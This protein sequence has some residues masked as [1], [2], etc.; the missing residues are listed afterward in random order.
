[1]HGVS[2]SASLPPDS[3]KE[4]KIPPVPESER[5]PLSASSSPRDVYDWRVRYHDLSSDQHQETVIEFFMKLYNS[6]S[7]Y[8]P[9]AP[10]FLSMLSGRR[11]GGGGKTRI[12]R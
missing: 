7:I 10:S 12:P 4:T 5:E 6:L 1:M 9:A 11:W 3:C 8:R 2:V